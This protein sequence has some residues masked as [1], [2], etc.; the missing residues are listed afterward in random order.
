M[1]WYNY[2][3]LFTLILTSIFVIA[4]TYGNK[5]HKPSKKRESTSF[6]MLGLFS[7]FVAVGITNVVSL[8]LYA[9][10]VT[11]FVVA[12]VLLIKSKEYS[13]N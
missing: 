10:A 2:V 13:S 12:A 4:L 11:Y 7:W 3:S 9:L 6:F 1:E 8:I 5:Q